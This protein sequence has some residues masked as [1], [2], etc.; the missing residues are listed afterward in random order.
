MNRL[1]YVPVAQ[2]VTAYEVE[3]TFF[4]SLGEFGLVE[5]AVIEQTPVLH[6]DQLRNV[7]RV[8]RLRQDLGIDWEGIAVVVDLLAKIEALQDDL[9][10]IKNRLQM[11]ENDFR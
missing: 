5:I 1:E 4:D 9:T 10:H 11:Y 2:L 8:I 3:A 6:H 7:E